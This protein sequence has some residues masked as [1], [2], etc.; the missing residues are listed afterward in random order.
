VILAVKKWRKL[1]ESKKL[2]LTKSAKLIGISKKSLDDY[3]L[4]L[5]VGEILGFDYDSNLTNKMGDLRAYIR[6]FDYKVTGK[7]TK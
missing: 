4:V 3:Y 5:R 2:N 7:L 1:Y 6:S